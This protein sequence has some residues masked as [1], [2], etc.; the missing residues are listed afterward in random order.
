MSTQPNAVRLTIDATE[1][2]RT[3]GAGGGAGTPVNVTQ[4]AGNTVAA[5]PAAALPVELF[6]GTNPLGTTSNPLNDNIAKVG[7]ATIAAATANPPAGTEVVPIERVIQRKSSSIVFGPATMPANTSPVYDSG[8]I[9]T[10]GTGTIYIEVSTF[11]SAT[12]SG[13]NMTLYQTDDS[14]NTNLQE[15]LGSQNFV[16]GFKFVGALSKRYYRFIVNNPTAN[17]PTIEIAITQC[18]VV[19][20]TGLVVTRTN[21]GSEFWTPVMPLI[22]GAADNQATQMMAAAGTGTGVSSGPVFVCNGYTTTS[23]NLA[24]M[25]RTPAVF[26]TVSATAA[27]NTALWTPT[28]GKKFRLM[29]YIVEVTSNANLAAG[30][31]EVI[32]MQDSAADIAQTHSVWIP[33][34]SVTTGAPPLFVSGWIDLGNGILSA[35][36][37][38]VLNVNLGTALAAGAVRVTCCGTEE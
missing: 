26:K 37:N 6:D 32:S 4:V 13:A 20:Q 27:G 25:A 16:G 24:V 31:V 21:N 3:T 17:T 33:T 7:G 35:S 10:L 38:N 28:A 22:T 23:G 5:T 8:W 30:A 19:P 34:T 15:T 18:A 9:D 1:E 2:I 12:I 36:A 29:R 11:S 14:S